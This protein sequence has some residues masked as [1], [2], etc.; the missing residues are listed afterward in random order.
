MTEMLERVKTYQQLIGGSFVDAASGETQEVVNPAND[1]V[2]ANVP[3]SAAEDVD[4]AV[5]AAATAFETYKQTTP[6]TTSLMLLKLA[7]LL[8]A[9]GDELGRLES[10]NAGKPVGAAIDDMALCADLF[11][12]FAGAAR[13]WTAWRRTSSSPATPRSSGATRSGSLPRS[14][15][16]TP[17]SAWPRGSS[18]RPSLPATRWSSSRRPARR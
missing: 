4:R 8:E 18:V 2:I 12:F 14:P 5:N 13:V 15:R 16:G 7:D 1:Q 6:I 9:K 17:R 3:K 10:Q 11:R